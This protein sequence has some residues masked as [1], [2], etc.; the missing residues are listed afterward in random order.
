MKRLLMGL[1]P[2]LALCTL[3]LGQ[4]DPQ[5]PFQQYF[6]NGGTVRL[7]L[8]S[9]D[10]TVRAGTSDRIFV[11][12]KAENSRYTRD[13]KNI[14]V[15]AAALAGNAATIRTEGPAKHAR[16]TIEVPPKTNLYLRMRAG[17]VKIEGIE[18]DKDIH[19]TAG[20]LTIE[21]APAAYS[22]VH[23]SVKVGDLKARPLGI[24]KDGLGNSFRW[25]GAGKYKLDATL[26]AGDLTLSQPAVR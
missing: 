9:G 14:R 20:D 8:A 10:Y 6:A 7:M 19:M 3:V 17:D 1:A 4:D 23:A 21:V 18:G 15:K 11:S 16:V 12:W 22:S 13:M 25:S 5:K 24:S 2:G 26:F